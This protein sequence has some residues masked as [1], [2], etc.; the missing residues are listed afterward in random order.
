MYFPFNLEEINPDEMSWSG[1][2]NDNF[3]KVN[4]ALTPL[5]DVYDSPFDGDVL[6]YDSASSRYI[7]VPLG[8]PTG[9]RPGSPHLGQSY[10]DSTLG[11][12]IWWSG[13]AW[14]DSQGNTV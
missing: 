2:L 9:S 3:E 7:K 8:G 13:S 6:I 10:F 11:Y 14:V 12:P 4:N 5:V 1:S